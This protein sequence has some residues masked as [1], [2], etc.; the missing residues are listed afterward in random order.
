MSTVLV[1]GIRRPPGFYRVARILRRL[2]LVVLVLLM[3]FVAT[4]GYSAY[5][6]VQASPQSGG[7]YSAAFAA[8]DTVAVTGSVSLSN[9]GY[10]PV[11]GFS[12]GLRILNASG[13]LIGQLRSDPV[14]IGAGATTTFPVSLSLPLATAAPV[15]SLLVADQTLSVGVWGNATYAYLFPVSVHF[16]QEKSWGAPFAN[17]QITAG[18]PSAGSNGFVVPITISFANHADFTESG[19]LRLALVSVGG[20]VCGTSSFPMDVPPGSLYD[21]TENV[22]LANGCS[23]AGGSAETTFVSG[24]ETIS[25]PPEPI[26]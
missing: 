26:P 1:G 23:V 5:Q 15:V 3:L 24:G 2:S 22:V 19:T 7:G 10:Y 8:N 17:F 9:P 20:P 18:T 4:A 21:Q 25:L 13:A 6:F 12:L 14:T 11:A 16:D